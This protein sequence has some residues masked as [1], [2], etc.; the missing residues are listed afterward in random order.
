[1][2]QRA[3]MHGPGK[4]KIPMLWDHQKATDSDA[5]AELTAVSGT[6]IYVDVPTLSYRGRVYQCSCHMV[7]KNGKWEISPD[8]FYLRRGMNERAP[9]TYEQAIRGLI[10]LRFA[11]WVGQY[12]YLKDFLRQAEIAYRNNLLHRLDGERDKL[13]SL[14]AEV[15]A[16]A[17]LEEAAL[18]A[19]KSSN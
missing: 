13:E 2:A 5:S 6:D 15:N 8:S 3:W 12:Q 1:M 9:H 14:L 4:V 17:S 16:K 19:A 18:A 7:L 10:D 11:T